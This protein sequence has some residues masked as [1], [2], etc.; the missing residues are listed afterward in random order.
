MAPDTPLSILNYLRNTP[1]S[2]PRSGHTS[3]INT[4]LVAQQSVAS[5]LIRCQRQGIQ[6]NGAR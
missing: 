5:L 1:R 4:P 3:K 2:I 6:H